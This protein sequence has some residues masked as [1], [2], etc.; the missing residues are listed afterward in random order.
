V[1][2]EA[3]APVIAA[4]LMFNTPVPELVIVTAWA[5]LVEPDVTF[6]KLSAL[7]LTVAVPVPTPVPLRAT[8]EATGVCV[9]ASAVVTVKVAD[10]AA[11]VDGWNVTERVH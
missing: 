11:I 5:V 6:P 7:V 10:S 3:F 1:K 8:V 9:V 4:E 2:S